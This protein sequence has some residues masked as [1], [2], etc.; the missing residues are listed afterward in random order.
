MGVPSTLHGSLPRRTD[1]TSRLDSRCRVRIG[2][3]VRHAVLER[4]YDYG[5]GHPTTRQASAVWHKARWSEDR[6]LA[7]DV[8]RLGAD[9]DRPRL[10]R[11]PLA[12][13]AAPSRERRRRSRG[14]RHAPRLRILVVYRCS[15]ISVKHGFLRVWCMC[16]TVDCCLI[17]TQHVGDLTLEQLLPGTWHVRV[18]RPAASAAAAPSRHPSDFLLTASPWHDVCIS[19]RHATFPARWQDE[20]VWTPFGE[21]LHCPEAD[22][23]PPLHLTADPR[24]Q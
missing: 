17:H 2:P 13:S 1:S 11:R 23:V 9:G 4:A 10:Q 8:A 21:R 14:S 7:R 18:D 16:I 6:V 22:H 20:T 3:G 19:A 15:C 12:A 24:R 5:A